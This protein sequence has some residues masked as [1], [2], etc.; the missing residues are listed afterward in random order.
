ME[1]YWLGTVQARVT[2]LDMQGTGCG[3]KGSF[4]SLGRVYRGRDR[5][6]RPTHL[7]DPGERC[8]ESGWEEMLDEV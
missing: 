7:T 8:A 5:Q 2:R 3:A 6:T 1:R 4:G